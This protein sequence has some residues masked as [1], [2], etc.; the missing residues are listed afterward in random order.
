MTVNPP[1]T[2]GE[3]WG[4]C[5]TKDPTPQDS[6]YPVHTLA[7]TVPDAG[8]FLLT[9]NTPGNAVWKRI[10]EPA[11]KKAYVLAKKSAD[12]TIPYANNVPVFFEQIEYNIGNC[13]NEDTGYFTAPRDGIY[14]FSGT[15]CIKP[16]ISSS[17]NSPSICRWWLERNGE[18]YHEK[19]VTNANTTNSY[20]RNLTLTASI[21]LQKDQKLRQLLDQNNKSGESLVIEGS[22]L[23]FFSIAEI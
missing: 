23:S 11:Y 14:I 6:D 13:Y 16:F 4:Y 9:D 19:F 5:F 10:N 17:L 15:I 18:N 22:Y 2:I 21:Y 3:N 12:Q 7:F 20:L 1:I 8:M